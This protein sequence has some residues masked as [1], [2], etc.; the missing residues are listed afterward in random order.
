MFFGE[1]NYFILLVVLEKNVK[2]DATPKHSLSLEIVGAAFQTGLTH[3]RLLQG[4]ANNF[5]LR[6]SSRALSASLHPLLYY[7]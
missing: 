1:N 4:N 3:P 7:L 6:Q 5:A 2:K